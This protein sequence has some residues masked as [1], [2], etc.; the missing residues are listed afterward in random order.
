MKQLIFITILLFNSAFLF[1]QQNTTD[2]ST[3]LSNKNSSNEIKDVKNV[4]KL[5]LG[6]TGNVGAFG[7]FYERMLNDNIS[8][9]IGIFGKYNSSSI[10][11]SSFYSGSEKTS[12]LGIMP[13]VRFYAL[14][15]YHAPR[16]LYLGAFY[17]Y[18]NEKYE[19]KNYDFNNDETNGSITTSYNAFGAKIGWM[20]R[21]KSAFVI[22]LGFGP[23]FE[24]V[25]SPSF[26]DIKL[27]NGTV[28]EKKRSPNTSTSGLTG[29]FS[30]SLGYAF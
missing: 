10:G 11:G 14:P 7:M 12:G 6:Q 13:E 24:I 3:K 19:V 4:V 5:N 21:I 9:S 27:N 29:V 26:Y 28:I 15:N 2:N 8:A 30:F 23:A 16:G 22:D 1:S 17:N 18:F 25:E 20:F